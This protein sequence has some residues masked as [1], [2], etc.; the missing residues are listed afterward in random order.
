MSKDDRSRAG[1]FDNQVRLAPMPST[2]PTIE[3]TLLPDGALI[4]KYRHGGHYTDCFMVELRQVITLEQFVEAFYTTWVFKLERG[5]IRAF[6]RKRS[7]DAQARALARGESEQFAAWTVEERTPYQLLM[8]DLWGSTR[9]WLM[10]AGRGPVITRLYF[11]SAVVGK[12]TSEGG[13][14]RMG[15]KYR[16]MLGFHTLY[17]RVLLGAAVRK[18][19]RTGS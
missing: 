1:S 7:S 12:A 6:L 19:R 16:A 4:D 15:L 13:K 9:S 17:S 14:P 18:L 2:Q 10:A 5:I 8:R 11:G 3:P